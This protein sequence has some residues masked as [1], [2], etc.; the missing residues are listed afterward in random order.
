MILSQTIANYAHARAF[1]IMCI[2]KLIDVKIFTFTSTLPNCDAFENN[3]KAKH[4]CDIDIWLTFVYKESLT[5]VPVHTSFSLT[6]N[7]MCCRIT[8]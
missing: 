4:K 2:H 7:A 6:L 3:N 1:Y 8:F 5:R